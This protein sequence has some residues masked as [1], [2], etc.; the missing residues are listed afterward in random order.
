MFLLLLLFYIIL[1]VTAISKAIPRNCHPQMLLFSA[2]Y[3]P[4]IK[5]MVQFLA[6]DP[7]QITKTAK[8][9]NLTNI[10]QFYV[11]VD[12]TQKMTIINDLYSVMTF[13]QTIIFCEKR[14]TCVQL[15]EFLRSSGHKVGILTGGLLKE[16]R[17][18]IM[19]EFRGGVTKIL[20][21]TNVMSRGIDVSGVTLVINYDL[22]INIENKKV[23]CETYLHRI[24][25][26]GRMGKKGCAVNLIANGLDMDHLNFIKQK[27]GSTITQ[28]PSDNLELMEETIKKAMKQ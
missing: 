3:P 27:Y 19:Q 28:L 23:D 15:T 11:N 4:Q 17:D 18:T 25:R 9:L 10:V 20:I 12:K 2:T 16:Q 21:T 26:T 14:I 1:A 5:K 24:G 8:E 22:P 6:P 7:L 13:G